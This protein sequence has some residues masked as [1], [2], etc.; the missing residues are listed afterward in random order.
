MIIW[1]VTEK[2]LPGLRHYNP[3]KRNFVTEFGHLLPQPNE[4]TCH[5]MDRVVNDS[6]MKEVVASCNMSSPEVVYVVPDNLKMM[7]NKMWSIANSKEKEEFK[8]FTVAYVKDKVIHQKDFN[9][10]YEANQAFLKIPKCIPTI[11][12]SGSGLN[13]VKMRGFSFRKVSDS[14]DAFLYDKQLGIRIDVEVEEEAYYDTDVFKYS[15]S[16]INGN[17]IEASSLDC[18]SFI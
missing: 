6:H 5:W 17:V 10:R 8:R 4:S 14:K 7:A 9:T 1:F 18:I 15:I 12:V 11:C 13:T 16:D 3:I 2:E